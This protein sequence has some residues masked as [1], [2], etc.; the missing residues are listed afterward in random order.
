MA[1]SPQTATLVATTVSTL[2]Y[3]EDFPAV[4]VMNVTGTAAVFVRFDGV[5][6]T[7]GGAGCH[8]VPA[9]AGATILR[10]PRTSGVTVVKLISSGTPQVSARGL[11]EAEL[12]S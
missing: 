6:P 2:T 9:T 3:D 10:K 5:N 1:A 8:V 12:N 4:E 7:V 11:T